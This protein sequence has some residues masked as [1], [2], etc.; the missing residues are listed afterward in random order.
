MYIC[1][2]HGSMVILD[3]SAFFYEG[4]RFGRWSLWKPP[5]NSKAGSMAGAKLPIWLPSLYHGWIDT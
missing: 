5:G 1:S 3:T 2:H 4:L